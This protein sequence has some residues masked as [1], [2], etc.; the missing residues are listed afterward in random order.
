MTLDTINKWFKNHRGWCLMITVCIVALFL[1]RP[2]LDGNMQE[3][4]LAISGIAVLF[5]LFCTGFIADAV[6]RQTE[7]IDKIA[8]LIE[9]QS[10]YMRKV[11]DMLESQ[12]KEMKT[13]ADQSQNTMIE[14]QVPKTPSLQEYFNKGNG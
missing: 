6:E 1:I 9:Q 7:R 12:Y 3:R 14:K 13:F 4:I 2:I 10:E 11:A 8:D 5:Y